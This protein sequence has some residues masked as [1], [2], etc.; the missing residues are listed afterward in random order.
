MLPLHLCA[1]HTYAYGEFIIKTDLAFQEQKG[2]LVCTTHV[3]F[4]LAFMASLSLSIGDD[5]AF[6]QGLEGLRLL[7]CFQVPSVARR[8]LAT[9][10]CMRFAARCV[11]VEDAPCG[12][13]DI[14]A[15][16]PVVVAEQQ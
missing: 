5:G 7:V 12:M 10:F 3:N 4:P 16:F 9:R 1:Y 13:V 11:V 8:A 14:E 2:L 6:P 15:P